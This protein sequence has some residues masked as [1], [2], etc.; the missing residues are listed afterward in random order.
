MASHMDEDLGGVVLASGS[1]VKETGLA[2]VH[3]GERILP[4][5][6]STAV[7]ERAAGTAEAVHYHFPVEIVV[8]GA[9]SDAEQRRLEAGIWERLA[10]ALERIA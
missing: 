5:P 7:M 4:A 10:N 9:L 3:E 6:G 2:V 1:V 8:V